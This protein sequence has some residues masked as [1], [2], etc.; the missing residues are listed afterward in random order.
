VLVRTD[1]IERHAIA[2]PDGAGEL[3]S[4]ADLHRG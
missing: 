4:L 3:I 1:G 2:Y